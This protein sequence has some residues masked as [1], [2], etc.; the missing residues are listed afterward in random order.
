MK[1]YLAGPYSARPRLARVAEIIE[2]TSGWQCTSRWLTGCHDEA[3][4]CAAAQ[5]DMADV[6][7]AQAL[8]IDVHRP[9]TRGGMWVE[10][11]LALG[12]GLP[13]VALRPH[14]YL[15]VFAHLPGV[16]R[17]HTAAAAGRALL[18]LEEESND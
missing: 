11:G 1:F 3:D 6:R 8:V 2:Q 18:Q 17:V 10:F 15:T 13:I 7:A 4:P 12:L 16:R 14:E 9:S 5:D